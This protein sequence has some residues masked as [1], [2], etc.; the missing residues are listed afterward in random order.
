MRFNLARLRQSPEGSKHTSIKQI[1]VL[2]LI[3]SLALF[4]SSGCTPS[5]SGSADNSAAV[6]SAGT[7]VEEDNDYHP[8]RSP[9]FDDLFKGR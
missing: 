6:R 1:P 8:P 4:G 3:G 7:A 2:F 5:G 9:G